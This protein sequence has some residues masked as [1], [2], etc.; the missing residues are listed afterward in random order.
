[1]G[2]AVVRRRPGLGGGGVYWLPWAE[3]DG[4]DLFLRHFVLLVDALEALKQAGGGRI[5]QVSEAGFVQARGLWGCTMGCAVVRGRPGLRGGGVCWLP[6]AEQGSAESCWP[7]GDSDHRRRLHQH[8]SRRWPCGVGLSSVR[9]AEF[10]AFDGLAL[11]AIV[12]PPI[13]LADLGATALLAVAPPPIVLTDLAP[14]AIPAL[15]PNPV[16]Q[17][18]LGASTLL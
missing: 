1:M 14:L 3:K 5:Q 4:G 13:V 8:R 11:L 17:A 10:G 9:L 7:L 6:W 12:P 15:T 16:V 18:E 2:C